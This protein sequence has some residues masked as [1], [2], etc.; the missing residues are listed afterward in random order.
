MCRAPEGS[1]VN[2]NMV[3]LLRLAVQ[4]S[5]D[6]LSCEGIPKAFCGD[7]R[8]KSDSQM[9]LREHFQITTANDSNSIANDPRS[10]IN[11]GTAGRVYLHPATFAL[12]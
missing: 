7:T 3:L 5:S 1:G 12:L 9:C 8:I 4:N 2:L 10:D 11:G 6:I